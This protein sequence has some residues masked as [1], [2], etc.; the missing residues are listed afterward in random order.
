MTLRDPE[1]HA[2][3]TGP[4]RHSPSTSY[5]KQ[6][7]LVYLFNF[8]SHMFTGSK[9]RDTALK[10][11]SSREGQKVNHEGSV[12]TSVMAESQ[13][14]IHATLK[15]KKGVREGFLEEEPSRLF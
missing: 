11:R 14:H 10:L 1:S 9:T 12:F 8:F 2:L 5:R 6:L 4:A 3:R 15:A 13:T 7:V